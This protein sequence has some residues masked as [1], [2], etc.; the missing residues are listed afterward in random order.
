VLTAFA[1]LKRR[2]YLVDL[3]GRLKPCPPHKDRMGRC[4]GIFQGHFGEAVKKTDLTDF[5]CRVFAPNPYALP[6]RS[7]YMALSKNLTFTHDEHLRPV[8]AQCPYC[9]EVMPPPDP[10]FEAPLQAILWGTQQF[11]QHRSLK[12]PEWGE[13]E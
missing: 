4:Q 1:G 3:N 7:H 5:I 11:I 10:G 8:S 6:Q 12:H 9:G 13:Q 2:S